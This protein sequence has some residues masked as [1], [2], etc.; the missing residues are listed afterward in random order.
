MAQPAPDGILNG[1]SVVVKTP[2]SPNTSE[3]S[4]KPLLKNVFLTNRTTT[5]LA[6][7]IGLFIAFDAFHIDAFASNHT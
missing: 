7:R 1:Y 5:E 2:K 6:N 4:Y 3:A